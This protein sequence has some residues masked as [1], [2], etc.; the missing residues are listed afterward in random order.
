MSMRVNDKY[1]IKFT[2]NALAD[3]EQV[4]GRSFSE[5][6]SE[7]GSG[8]LRISDLRSLIMV[9][10]RHGTRSAARFSE[11]DAGNLIDEVGYEAIAEAI[12][13]AFEEAFPA[14]GERT[15]TDAGQDDD[16]KN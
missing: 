16:A 11:M 3:L 13:K 15:D 5:V 4:S 8:R 6:V 2:T 12:G 9:G 1:E 14:A 10:V 7:F